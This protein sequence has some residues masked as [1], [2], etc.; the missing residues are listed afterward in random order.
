LTVCAAPKRRPRG[1]GMNLTKVLGEAGFPTASR[2]K[3]QIL[4]EKA[5]AGTTFEDA[6]VSWTDDSIRIDPLYQRNA[7]PSLL[8]RRN[9]QAPW[10]VVQRLDDP[11]AERAYRQALHEVAQGATGLSLV[12]EGAP[13][14]FG[15]GLPSTRDTLDTVLDG[16][17]LNRIS[18]RIDVH[19]A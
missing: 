6:L 12:F 17:P 9:P 8:P 13:S 4:A 19:P 14:A 11:D 3:W 2:E 7:D 1:N 10:L 18:L 16:I 5:L 15:Y